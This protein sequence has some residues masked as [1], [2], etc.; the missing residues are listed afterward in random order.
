MDKIGY[1]NLKETIYF[2]ELSNGLKVYILHR[3]GFAKTY[4]TFTT[5]YGSIDNTFV[6]NGE[7]FEVPDGIAHFLEHKM[8]EEEDGDVFQTFARYGAQTN[9]FTSF[10]RTTYL[11]SSTEHIKKHLETLL[12]FVQH[13][14]FTDENVEK[15]KG[16]IAQE[17]KMY[18]DNPDWRLYFGLIKSLYQQNPIR[19]DIAGT[20]ESIYKITKEQLYKCYKTFYH[21]SNMILFVTSGENPNELMET[22]KENQSKKNFTEIPKIDRVYPIESE[23]I[24]EKKNE[25]KLSVSIPKTLLGFKE[26][27]QK[28]VGKDF[29]K[30]ELSTQIMLELL[31][32]QSSDIYE[33][34]LNKGLISE[35]YGYEYQ[36]ESSYA[37]SIIGGN[38]KDPNQFI[39]LISNEIEK[40]KNEG[41]DRDTFERI[42]KKKIGDFLRKLNSPEYIANQFT[43]YVF[44]GANLFDILSIL[45]AMTMTDIEK[46]LVSL[47]VEKMAVS[48]VEPN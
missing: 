3:E 41:L 48:I 44:N 5:Q 33:E 16:I 19:I 43:R 25:I 26:N 37:F 45:E 8:F 7:K 34:M 10:N 30:K 11:F 27:E 31:V 29:I 17:I 12:N 13:P 20:V 21:P 35:D 23:E 2:E 15:E 36:I 38:T 47:D 46:R 28:I 32:G 42:K 40:K 39:N 9:A 24:N 4:A 6:V 1:D 22:I 18:E 14:Y